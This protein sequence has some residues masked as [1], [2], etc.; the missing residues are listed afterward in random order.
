MPKNR[1]K[2]GS[3]AKAARSI[4]TAV[5]SDAEVAADSSPPATS[6]DEDR[7]QSPPLDETNSFH[8]QYAQEDASESGDLSEGTAEPNNAPAGDF[9]SADEAADAA[10]GSE[11]AGDIVSDKAEGDDEGEVVMRI[12]VDW[13]GEYELSF[14][15]LKNV[16]N[17][18]FLNSVG[19]L[20][21]HC[22][23]VFWHCMFALE[24][25]ENSDEQFFRSR[26]SRLLALCVFYF[27]FVF[28]FLLLQST[29]H[30]PT[31]EGD[32]TMPSSS[33]CLALKETATLTRR[34]HLFVSR[35]LSCP[36]TARVLSKTRTST[37]VCFCRHGRRTMA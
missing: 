22:P 11:N 18:C 36:I 1:S 5:P 34:Y 23:G 31:S 27:F 19:M 3:G 28:C 7:S 4:E 32:T 30:P 26:F 17:T 21:A 35:A 24:Q 33:W 8:E 15:G 10:F 20:L 12:P 9:I 14:C 25:R 29:P 16:G 37:C 6:H 2:S 13:G